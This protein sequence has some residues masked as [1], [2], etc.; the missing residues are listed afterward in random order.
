MLVLVVVTGGG[1][2]GS[3]S[4]LGMGALAFHTTKF[5]FHRAAL[6]SHLLDTGKTKPVATGARIATVAFDL[7]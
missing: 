7:R 2:G 3:S 6:A 1:G 4:H 5:H